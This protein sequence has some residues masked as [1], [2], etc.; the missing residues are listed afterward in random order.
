MRPVPC[1]RSF[2]CV[3]RHA[4]VELTA[5]A[6]ERLRL[7]QAWQRLSHEG[8]AGARAAQVLGISR[9]ILYRWHKGVRRPMW[10]EDLV[11]AACR[12]RG[13]HP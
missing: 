10:S 4:P 7:L 5:K 13:A 6:Q 12:L 9:A 11:A 8:M 2:Y 3:A 1:P